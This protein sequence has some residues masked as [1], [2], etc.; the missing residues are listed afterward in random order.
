VTSGFVD[1]IQVSYDTLV[2]NQTQT[3]TANRLLFRLQASAT[4]SSLGEFAILRYLDS[5]GP[6]VQLAVGGM[7]FT[8]HSYVPRNPEIY[9]TISDP[10]G[11]DRTAGKFYMMLDGDTIPAWQLN[12]SD[13]LDWGNSTEVLYRPELDTGDHAIDVFATDNAGNNSTTRFEFTVRSDFGIE[14]ALNYPNPFSKTTTIAYVLT[15]ATD[16]K[17]EV[18]IYTVA[19]RLI[20]TLRDPVR[21]TVNYRELTWDG[22]DEQGDEVA[23]G[24]YFAKIKAKRNNQ[25]VEDV[26]KL[27]KVR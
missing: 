26:V 18:K 19:G 27:A 24:V 13:T 12:R 4:T 14:W 10:I 1:T 16:E 7:N 9:A 21:E 15:G 2:N 17:V 22:R 8:Q 6:S 11:V 3:F 23:N 25:T 20:R 5:Q